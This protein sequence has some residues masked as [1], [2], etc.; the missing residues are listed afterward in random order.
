[1]KVI[2]SKAVSLTNNNNKYL[3]IDLDERQ[4]C[5]YADLE[6]G[7]SKKDYKWKVGCK[8]DGNTDEYSFKISDVGDVN[9]NDFWSVITSADFATKLIDTYKAGGK[10]LLE[11]QI[12]SGQLY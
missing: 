2:N 6:R 8:Y 9:D 12:K 11:K 7:S 5:W 4:P 10:D 1:M 3:P